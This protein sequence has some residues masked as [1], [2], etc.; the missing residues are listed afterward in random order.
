MDLTKAKLYDLSHTIY[1][2]CPAYPKMGTPMVTRTSYRA[3]EGY[4]AEQLI[5]SDHTTTHVDTPEHFY[6]G[7]GDSA[8]LP[9]EKFWGMGVFVDLRGKVQAESPIGPDLLFPYDPE[10]NKGDFVLINTGWSLKRGFN[11]D[12]LKKWPYLNGLGAKYLKEKQVGAVGI[13]AMSLGGL[14]SRDKAQQCHEELLGSGILILE[15]I[16]F[17]PEVMDGK[18]R[19]VSCFPL[20]IQGGSASPVRLVAYDF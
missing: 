13:D 17:P 8:S 5:I 12:Y 16:F 3:R 20:K 7:T 10:I 1:H 4:N 11:E 14:G 18:K 19:L 6:Q 15:E 9:L 2:G